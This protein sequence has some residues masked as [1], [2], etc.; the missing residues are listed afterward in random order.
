MRTHFIS[1]LALLVLAAAGVFASQYWS[2]DT[3]QWLF[4]AGGIAI[5]ALALADAA[6]PTMAQRG[7]DGLVA[8][9]GAWTIVSSFLFDGNDLRWWSFAAAVA[10]GALAVIGLAIHEATTERVVHELSVTTSHR[11]PATIA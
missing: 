9:L 4:F 10:A 5:I 1:R 3:L 11:D 6:R 2:G 7:L 8:L